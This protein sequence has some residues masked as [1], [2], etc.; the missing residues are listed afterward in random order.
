MNLQ[1]KLTL[2]ATETAIKKIPLVIT[3]TD[4][5]VLKRFYVGKVKYSSVYEKDKVIIKDEKGK[6]IKTVDT[7]KPSKHKNKKA[8]KEEP[9]D[10]KT[11]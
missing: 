7:S 9:K 3:Q 1:D 5:I 8:D 6:I 11:S 4:A 10:H 2:L